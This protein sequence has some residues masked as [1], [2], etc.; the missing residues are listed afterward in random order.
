MVDFVV[1]DTL[2]QHRSGKVAC[3]LLPFK[4]RCDAG[5]V[6]LNYTFVTE[7]KVETD[8]TQLLTRKCDY[9]VHIQ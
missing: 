2:Q 7:K 5:A 9:I 6:L 4:Y 8:F 3:Y 1:T